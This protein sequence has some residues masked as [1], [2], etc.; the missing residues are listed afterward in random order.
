MKAI[1]YGPSN[2]L[3]LAEIEKPVPADDEVLLRIRAASVNPLDGH[4]LKT[5]PWMRN[6]MSK[7]VGIRVR[8]PGADVAGDVEAVGRNVT[9]FK[10]G[11][12]VFGGSSG[13]GF[14]EYACPSES[15]LAKMPANISFESA[16]SVNVAGRTA[17]QGLRDVANVQ[18]GQ[19][20]LINGASGGVGTF[21]VQIAKWM[22]ADVTGV[23]STRNVDLVRGL[24]ADHVIDYT[25]EDIL[26][27]DERYDVI[28]DLVSDKP[29]L[30]LRRILTPKGKWIGA[31][32]L[33]V[34]AS[35][36][37]M[38]ASSLKTP[39]LSLFTGQKFVSFMTKTGNDDLDVLAKLIESGHVTPA[40]DRT[41]SLD[42]V[43]NAV[44]YVDAK[45]AR[46]KVVISAQD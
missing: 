13:G 43:A 44:C 6:L 33:G 31:G 26:R 24:G 29:L 7:A 14:A 22:G 17:L 37:S 25:C 46:G 35:M 41:Y 3:Q 20:V 39:L 11:D 34:D 40:I 30:A 5:A 36:I 12:A 23:C 21:A 8:R 28:F 42:E 18:S 9:R 1:I 27:V 15:K 4:L 38:I 45:H 10:L 32:V 16:A 19:K 2:T